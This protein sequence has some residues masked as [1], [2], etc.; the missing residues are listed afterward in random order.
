MGLEEVFAFTAVPSN[1]F[2]QTAPFREA[3]SMLL[4]LHC[5]HLV[6]LVEESKRV[7]TFLSVVPRDFT[8]SCRPTV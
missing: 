3:F 1:F 2:L 6:E 4:A 5:E 7:Q 8:L